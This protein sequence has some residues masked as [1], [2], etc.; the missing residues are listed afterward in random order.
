[1]NLAALL[2][3]QA[4]RFGDRVLATFEDAMVTYAVL[5]D[6][7]A[8][9]AGGLCELGIVEGDRVAVMMPNRAEFLYVWFGIVKLGAIEVPLHSAARGPGIAHSRPRRCAGGADPHHAERRRHPEA[10]ACRPRRG[11]RPVSG[12]A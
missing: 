7:A 6:G 5:A 1:M 3:E 10:S 4:T 2:D 8:R 9:F 12:A 11:H